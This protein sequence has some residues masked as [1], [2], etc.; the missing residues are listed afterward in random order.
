[1]EARAFSLGEDAPSN[2]SKPQRQPIGGA[3]I[4]K[5]PS[6]YASPPAAIAKLRGGEREQP[7]QQTANANTSRPTAS[8]GSSESKPEPTTP[9]QQRQRPRVATRP[10][11]R[12]VHTTLTQPQPNA[13]HRFLSFSFILCLPVCFLKSTHKEMPGRHSPVFSHQ[14]PVI[15]RH[16]QCFYV[17][18]WL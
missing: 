11:L 5:H 2:L 15:P 3:S 9:R 4:G 13:C 1:M 14:S 6:L 16:S 12:W 10:P 7:H 8:T 18:L 17:I